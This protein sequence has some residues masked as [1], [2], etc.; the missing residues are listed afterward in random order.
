MIKCLIGSGLQFLNLYTGAV[1]PDVF[2]GPF[3]S[4]KRDHRTP[5]TMFCHSG[6]RQGILMKDSGFPV[7]MEVP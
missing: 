2:Q 6:I 4:G 1:G 7:S 3:S 5:W